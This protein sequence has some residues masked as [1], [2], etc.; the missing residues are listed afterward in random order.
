[1][2]SDRQNF[3]ITRSV[4]SAFDLL[5]R[6]LNLPPGSEVVMSALTVPD[7]VRIVQLHGL[8]PIP[9]DTDVAGRIDAIALRKAVASRSRM[10][11]VAHLFR[12]WAALND[13]LEAAHDHRKT[14]RRAS[15]E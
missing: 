9:V 3:L 1:M 2:W 4:R 13:V 11:V 5:L 14:S 7:M 12:G 15:T 6:S 10:I 8:V